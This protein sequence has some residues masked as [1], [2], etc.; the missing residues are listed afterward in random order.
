MRRFT[1][2]ASSTTSSANTSST[3]LSSSFTA[4]S[5]FLRAASKTSVLVILRMFQLSHVSAKEIA[6]IACV[7]RC[8]GGGDARANPPMIALTLA[9][10]RWWP[11]HRGGTGQWQHE[12]E[13]IQQ[14][15]PGHCYNTPD[16]ESR[17]PGSGAGVRL[18]KSSKARTKKL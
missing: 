18:K 17:S 1:R 15:A 7:K 10:H 6:L 3:A 11:G 4:C 5:D 8:E 2:S 12:H 14:P 13:R 16:L 9:S